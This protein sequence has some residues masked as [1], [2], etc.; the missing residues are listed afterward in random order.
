MNPLTDPVS[1]CFI[2]FI[3]ICLAIFSYA[4]WQ[5]CR[6]DELDSSIDINHPNGTDPSGG[7]EPLPVNRTK[8]R[9][10][11]LICSDL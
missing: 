6:P 3:L 7:G 11:F 4:A 10:G 2:A 5:D 8:E 1:L 9:C